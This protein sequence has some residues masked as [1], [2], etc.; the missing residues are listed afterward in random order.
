MNGGGDVELRRLLGRLMLAGYRTVLLILLGVIG[1]LGQ[2]QLSDLRKSIEDGAS[3]ADAAAAAATQAVSDVNTR[4][5]ELKGQIEKVAVQ[6]QGVDDRV[7]RL[8]TWRDGRGGA[9]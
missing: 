8:E 2:L 6:V 7:D 1:F 3:K 4:A 5:A 9:R